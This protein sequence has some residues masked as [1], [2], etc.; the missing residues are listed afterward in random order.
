M[1]PHSSK[2]NLRQ[3]YENSIALRPRLNFGVLVF[4]KDTHTK[5]RGETKK[6]TKRYTAMQHG[7]KAFHR[8][9]KHLVMWDQNLSRIKLLKRSKKRNHDCNS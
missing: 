1:T 7:A 5:T 6:E 4:F 9:R 2:L 3:E 8:E